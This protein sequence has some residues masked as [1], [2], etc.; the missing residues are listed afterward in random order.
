MI[1][2]NYPTPPLA[3]IRLRLGLNLAARRTRRA[4]EERRRDLRA[5]FSNPTPATPEDA[6][7]NL[8][9]RED[10]KRERAAFD[11]FY[12]RYDALI[13]LLCAAAQEGITPEREAGYQKHR[14]W[15]CARYPSLK[16]K[17]HLY[18][19]DDPSDAGSPSRFGRRSHDAFEALFSPVSIA[20]LLAADDGDLIGRLMRTQSA[21]G[22]WEDGIARREAACATAAAQTPDS[23]IKQ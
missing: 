22:E 17:V 18:L 8:R 10:L 13:G 1:R 9:W 14:A 12:D 4:L 6:Y 19:S 7:L 2:I 21:L 5:A 16:R 11:L 3:Q 20:A 15:F 23:S